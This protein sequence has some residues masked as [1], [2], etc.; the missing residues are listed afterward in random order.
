LATAGT[1]PFTFVPALHNQGL[2]VFTEATTGTRDAGSYRRRE[3]EVRARVLYAPTSR[4]A[5]E[6]AIGAVDDDDIREDTRNN[7]SAEVRYSG[8]GLGLALGA[9]YRR[10]YEEVGVPYLRLVWSTSATRYPRGLSATVEFP[11][12]DDRDETDVM[13]AMAQGFPCGSFVSCAFEIA[14]ED[15]EGFA[16][17]EAEGG[18]KFSFGPTVSFGFESEHQLKIF[19]GWVHAATVNEPARAGY[20]DY[21]GHRDGAMFRISLRYGT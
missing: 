2:A 15:L 12:A 21:R 19:A 17:D 10:D 18:A 7:V 20:P 13:L 16:G 9:G 5:L 14:G 6:S 4:W 11:R 3:A 1:D 8:L